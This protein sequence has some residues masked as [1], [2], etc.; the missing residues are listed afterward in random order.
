MKKLVRNTLFILIMAACMSLTV[1]TAPKEVTIKVWSFSI[2]PEAIKMIENEIIPE[3]EKVNPGIKIKWQSIPYDGYREKLLTAAIGQ[4]LPDVFFDGSNM[5]GMYESKGLIAPIDK[6]LKDWKTWD[7]ILET[8]KK[9]AMYKGKYYGVP[10]RTKPNPPIYSVEAFKRAGLDPDKPPQNWD[11]L[12]ACGKKL[13]KV[14]NDRVVFQGIAGLSSKS[15]RIRSFDL[16]L[17]QNGGRMLTEDLSAPAFNS[18]EGIE[19]LKFFIELYKV[20]E[21]IGVAALTEKVVSN[22]AAGLVGIVPFDGYGTINSCLVNNTLDVL[23]KSRV[24]Q[25]ISS[26]KP[27]GKRVEMMDGDM[28]YLSARSKNQ[29]SAFA[30]MKFFYEPDNHLKY[31]EANKILPLEKSLMNSDYVRNTPFF[32]ELM[33]SDKYG[34]ELVNTPEYPEVRYLLLDEIDKAIYGKQTPEQA[35]ARAEEIWKKAIKE[36]R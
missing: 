24:S 2:I 8:P 17:Q 36:Y 35:L 10:S 3:F 23:E 28:A 34:W 27:G 4:D 26:G 19:A 25:P 5:V 20:S 14:K 21:P 6:Y 22:Y 9:Q 18:K 31:A 32:T 33:E 29:D 1:F 12:L 30:F 16:V 15:T 13:T 11:D 7:D